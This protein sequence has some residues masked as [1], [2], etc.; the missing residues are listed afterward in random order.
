MMRAKS[1]DLISQGRKKSFRADR[2]AEKP[3][4]NRFIK[5][6]EAGRKARLEFF[7]AAGGN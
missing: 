4:P 6:T 3:N 5:N 7:N 2:I 1:Q